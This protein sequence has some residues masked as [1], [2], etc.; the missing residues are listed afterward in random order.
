MPALM[1]FVSVMLLN[2][3]NYT[4]S[5]Q[6]TERQMAKQYTENLKDSFNLLLTE[7]PSMTVTVNCGFVIHL[8]NCTTKI[9]M[10]LSFCLKQQTK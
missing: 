2:G 9:E 8:L 5:R 7:L 6:A 4:K 3:I 1:G 10:L